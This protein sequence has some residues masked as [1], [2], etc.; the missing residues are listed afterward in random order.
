VTSAVVSSRPNDRG[1]IDTLSTVDAGMKEQFLVIYRAAFAPL[2]ELAPARQG[3]TDEEFV[4]Q[5]DDDTVVKVVG[6][7]KGDEPVAL[8]FMSPNLATVPWIS[9]QYFQIRFPDHMARS[10]VFYFGGLLVR[11]P[12]RAGPWAVLVLEEAVRHVTRAGGVAVFDCCA[13][14]VERKLPELI[15]RVARRICVLET[16]ELEPQRYFAYTTHGFKQVT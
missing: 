12:E 4:S 6:Y 16:E 11:E 3:L 1:R 13:H 5:M 14:N 8:T 7:N 15:A 10:A 2:D 9:P